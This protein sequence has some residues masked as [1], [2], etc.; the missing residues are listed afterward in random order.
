MSSTTPPM[1]VNGDVKINL[2]RVSMIFA[3]LAALFAFAGAWFILPYRVEATEKSAAEFSIRVERRFEATEKEQREQ[4]EILIRIDEN[5][6]QLKKNVR[7]RS[8]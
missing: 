4:R 5:V 6:K 1:S 3:F 7:D 2:T 8:E